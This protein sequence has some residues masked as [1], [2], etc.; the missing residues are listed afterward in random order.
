[1][2]DVK[3]LAVIQRVLKATLSQSGGRSERAGATRA[4]ITSARWKL[5]IN[6]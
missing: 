1:M 6:N 2:C 4:C 5:W 3:Y